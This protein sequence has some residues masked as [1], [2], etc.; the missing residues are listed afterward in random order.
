MIIDMRPPQKRGFSP[1]HNHMSKP[2]PE[3][4]YLLTRVLL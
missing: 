2:Y 3:A 4:K 1:A